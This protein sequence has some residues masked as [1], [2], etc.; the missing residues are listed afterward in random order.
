MLGNDRLIS[1]WPARGGPVVADGVVYFAAGLWPSDGI[2]V[3]A[4]DGRTIGISPLIL[5]DWNRACV[6]RMETTPERAGDQVIAA[7]PERIADWYRITSLEPADYALLPDADG[8]RVRLDISPLIARL[9]T[10]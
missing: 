6:L 2:Y 1:H 8:T 9:A 10:R 3:Y 4:L 5:D 7:L